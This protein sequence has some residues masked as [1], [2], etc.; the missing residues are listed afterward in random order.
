MNVS[1]S[2]TDSLGRM[3]HTFNCT[4]YEIEDFTYEALNSRGFIEIANAST[5]QTRWS[6]VEIAGHSESLDK[7]LSNVRRYLNAGIIVS[8][9]E[10]QYNRILSYDY[11]LKD[12]FG[13]QNTVAAYI[14]SPTATASQLNKIATILNKTVNENKTFTSSDYAKLTA[15]DTELAELLIEKVISTTYVLSSTVVN[16]STVL[17]TLEDIVGKITYA[18]GRI[19]TRDAKSIYIT[20]ML[21]GTIIE[22]HTKRPGRLDDVETI[23][24][25]ATGSYNAHFEKPIT[26]IVVP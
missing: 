10:E 4:A 25:G 23:Q 26:S 14:I 3:L 5:M 1:L 11:S 15:Y 13:Q 22:L 9:T 20:D 12:Y 19:N 18:T 8:V 16:N 21:P 7:V 6:T 17:K 2:P 24:I